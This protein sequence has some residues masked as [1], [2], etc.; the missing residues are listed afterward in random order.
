MEEIGIDWM[1][2]GIKKERNRC[3]Y[4]THWELLNHDWLTLTKLVELRVK[5]RLCVFSDSNH[6]GTAPFLYLLYSYP[7]L[8]V[9]FSQ[10][11]FCSV[12]S[13]FWN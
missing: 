8:Q 11:T 2:L 9:Y 4:R 6:R 3:V 5:V 10:S 7:A 12:T 1:E 13:R